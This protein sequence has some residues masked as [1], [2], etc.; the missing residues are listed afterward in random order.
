MQHSPYY[1]HLS[2]DSSTLIHKK[3][4]REIS[5]R[6]Q[7]FIPCLRQV[8]PPIPRQNIFSTIYNKVLQATGH[9]FRAENPLPP[10]EHAPI[11]QDSPPLPLLELDIHILGHIAS[12][13]SPQDQS[14]FELTAQKCHQSIV[15]IRQPNIDALQRAVEGDLINRFFCFFSCSSLAYIS[16]RTQY[17]L[18]HLPDDLRHSF[19]NTDT[20]LHVPSEFNRLLTTHLA[21]S[22]IALA[23]MLV[24]PRAIH[25]DSLQE[26]EQSALEELSHSSCAV[27][28][29]IL[30][31]PFHHIIEYLNTKHLVIIPPEIGNLRSLKHLRL[32]TTQLETLPP[33]IG[34]LRSLKA[35]DLSN[36]NLRALPRELADLHSLES[37]CLENNSLRSLP[38]AITILTSLRE[39]DI[40]NN[41][42]SRLP[43][44]IQQLRALERLD[45]SSN[46]LRSLPQ[47]ISSLPKLKTLDLNHNHLSSLPSQIGTSS[48][49]K[50]LYLLDNPLQSLPHQLSTRPFL[51]TISINQD[52]LRILPKATKNLFWKYT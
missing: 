47:E 22:R 5:M 31:M 20:L 18:D 38:K 25:G 41:N 1:W 46:Q 19:S 2:I 27:L 52:Q 10:Q 8:L 45:I 43:K 7:P 6:I 48:F 4:T 17:L 24:W 12:F 35:L 34:N 11:P 40:S 42:L 36:N 21:L 49:L 51:K 23:E 16:K 15:E 28:T 37:L 32:R 3:T 30:Q 50:D 39:L 14:S 33:E 29:D 44:R 9:F 13:L 26:R